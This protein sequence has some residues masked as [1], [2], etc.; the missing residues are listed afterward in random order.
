MLTGSQES[1]AQAFALVRS[2]VSAGLRDCVV[3]PGS[4]STPLVLALPHFPQ[5]RVRVILDER[6]AAFFAL[7]IADRTQQPVALICTSGTAGANY[8]PAVIEASERAVPLLLLT[9]DRPPELRDCG[10]GQTIDQVGLYGGFVRWAVDAA[11]PAGPAG[12]ALMASIARD[13]YRAAVAP[14]PGPV[15]FNLPFREPFLPESQHEPESGERTVL[16]TVARVASPSPDWCALQKAGPGVILAGAASPRARQRW[17]DG[18]FQV[19]DCLGWPILADVL[20]PLRHAPGSAERVVTQYEAILSADGLSDP[21]SGLQPQAVLQVGIL[22]TAKNLR[23]WASS[24]SGPYWQWSPQ[25]AGLNPGRVPFTWIPGSP[26]DAIE[27]PAGVSPDSF[28]AHWLECERTVARKVASWLESVPDR[29]EGKVYSTLARIVPS[30]AQ[31]FISNS[32][33][34]RDAERFWLGTRSQGPRIFANRGASG[35][36]GLVSTAAGLADGG[37]PT[38]A[39]LG[40]LAFLHDAGGLRAA[41]AVQGSLTLLVIDNGGGRIFEQLPIRSRDDVFETYFLTPQKVDLVGLCRAHGIEVQI[42]GGVE[43]LGEWARIPHKGARVLILQTD[44][45][46]DPGIRRDWSIVV[47]M[48][49]S[50]KTVK[51]S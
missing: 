7:G 33:P 50:P 6:S 4:R 2:L 22:P 49:I 19:S 42:M 40:D 17:A 3:S 30:D 8:Y 15:H 25:P 37:P 20:N 18:L 48:P 10:A 24:F 9:A 23:E 27:L 32:R 1:T 11:V 43:E 38:W 13:G 45:A 31:V 35:I 34:A 26:E 5:L 21:E 39:V 51:G 14:H 44:P 16:P 36:D 41:A 47:S 46:T 28:R 29:F 12:Q